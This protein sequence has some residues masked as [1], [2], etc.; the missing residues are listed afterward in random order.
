MACQADSP[1]DVLANLATDNSSNGGL[2]IVPMRTFI[3]K[4]A[5]RCNLNCTYCYVYNKG[6]SS[7]AEQPRVMPNAVVDAAISSIQNYSKKLGI[8][9]VELIF[10]GG[11]P[12]LAGKSFFRRFVSR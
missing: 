11:E 9:E 1:G 10:H 7:Y 3:L 8:E 5:S 6:D 12:L 4:V 2:P